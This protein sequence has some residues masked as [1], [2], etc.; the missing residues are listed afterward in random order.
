MNEIHNEE[1]WI[2]EFAKQAAAEEER[3]LKTHAST[4][5]RFRKLC[6]AHDLALD[7]SAFKYVPT[8][9][10]VIRIASDEM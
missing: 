8:I 6:L 9:G 4:I 1:Q 10:L 5:S 2:R 7:E 3:Q